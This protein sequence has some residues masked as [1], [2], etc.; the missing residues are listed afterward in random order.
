MKEVVL[1]AFVLVLVKMHQQ[2][3][4]LKYR[5]GVLSG[6]VDCQKVKDQVDQ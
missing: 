1:S 2:I 4:Q 5:N 6:Q 3:A